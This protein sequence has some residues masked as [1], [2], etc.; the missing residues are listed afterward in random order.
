MINP[1]NVYRRAK[2]DGILYVAP[3]IAAVMRSVGWDWVPEGGGFVPADRL[4]A[5]VTLR[6]SGTLR[7]LLGTS[8]KVELSAEVGV[9]S[10]V[11]YLAAAD[12]AG[13]PMCPWAG[14][15]VGPCLKNHGRLIYTQN[16]MAQ[17][18]KT[19]YRHFFWDEYLTQ[20]CTEIQKLVR[21]CRKEGS[22]PAVRLDGTSETGDGAILAHFF[23]EVVFYDY[24]KRP[25]KTALRMAGVD[26][27]AELPPNL[28]W[29][30]SIDEKHGTWDRA[31][32]YLR[33]GMGA[34][35]VVRSDCGTNAGAQAVARGVLE[36]GEINGWPV[37]DGDAHDARFLDA[38]GKVAVLYA[39][40]HRAPKDESGFVKR[41]IFSFDTGLAHAA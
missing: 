23:P 31:A 36:A 19:W 33:A 40:G 7:P 41:V 16:E 30:F 5:A 2:T 1:I 39:K 15:C 29:T 9:R 8:T 21:R 32:E 12:M 6:P 38:R 26:S 18:A 11:V 17:L 3:K 35:L 14:E 22:I 13:I 27:V 10:P 24:L 34:A 20:L 4:F 28:H 25:L 37:V